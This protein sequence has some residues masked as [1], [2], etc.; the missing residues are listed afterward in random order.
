VVTAV[1]PPRPARWPG[2]AARGHGDPCDVRMPAIL[3]LTGMC[4]TFPRG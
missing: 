3:K 1:R 4:L 2:W